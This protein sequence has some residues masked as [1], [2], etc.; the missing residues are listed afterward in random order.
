[1]EAMTN[2]GRRRW[3][4]SLS[5]V[6]LLAATV[7]FCLYSYSESQRKKAELAQ[8]IRASCAK[9]V[10]AVSEICRRGAHAPPAQ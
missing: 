7:L 1:M 10:P 8:A 3:L 9:E 5:T 4:P 6:A 2:P